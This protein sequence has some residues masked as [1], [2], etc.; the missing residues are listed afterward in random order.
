M[1]QHVDDYAIDLERAPAC[2][3]RIGII[4]GLFVEVEHGL[5]PILS[6][7]TGMPLDQAE[8]ALEMQKQNGRKMIFLQRMCEGITPGWPRDAAAGQAFAA[9][10]LTA[11]RIR[12]SYAH[13][14]YTLVGAAGSEELDVAVFADSPHNAMR[15][16]IA[17]VDILDAE[18]GFLKSLI[19]AMRNYAEARAANTPVNMQEIEALA[20]NAPEPLLRK[21]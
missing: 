1:P 15:V 18:I 8:V 7:T 13:A 3:R 21:P 5:V 6:W 20:A 2:A 12:N 10:A 9:A 19:V 14:T 11:N 16:Q 4:L 17:T